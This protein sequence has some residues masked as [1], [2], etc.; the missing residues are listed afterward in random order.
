MANDWA[1]IYGENVQ[2]T[3]L[4]GVEEEEALEDAA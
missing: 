4:P 2:K 3:E 1:T